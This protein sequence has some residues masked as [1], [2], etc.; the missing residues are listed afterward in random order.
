MENNSKNVEQEKARPLGKNTIPLVSETRDRIP[1]KGALKGYYTSDMALYDLDAVQTFLFSYETE[2][3]HSTE[4]REDSFESFMDDEY[5]APLLEM[6]YFIIYFNAIDLGNRKYHQKMMIEYNFAVKHNIPCLFV[7]PSL[8]ENKNETLAHAETIFGPRQFF[9]LYFSKGKLLDRAALTTKNKIAINLSRLAKDELHKELDKIFEKKAF[10]SYRKKDRQFIE[11]LLKAFHSQGGTHGLRIWYD[12]FLTG[13][14]EYSSDIEREL[15]SADFFIL[16]VTPSLLEKDNFVMRVEYPL[17]KKLGKII[18]PILVANTDLNEL[19]K[20]YPDLP[21]IIDFEQ[22]INFYDLQGKDIL[23]YHPD[24][25]AEAAKYYLTLGRCY[26]DGMEMEI[27]Y[28]LAEQMFKNASTYS[29]EGYHELARLYADEIFKKENLDL[30]IKYQEQYLHN[31]LP[32]LDLR[33][34]EDR[35]LYLSGCLEYQDY[36]LF[37]NQHTGFFDFNRVEVLRLDEYDEAS[38]LKF[39]RIVNIRRYRSNP[40][41]VKNLEAIEEQLFRLINKHI[42]LRPYIGL[43]YFEMAK[44]YRKARNKEKELE[45]GTRGYEFNLEYLNKPGIELYANKLV[46]YMQNMEYENL[47]DDKDF[48]KLKADSGYGWVWRL[49]YER[50]SKDFRF[51]REKIA[52]LIYRDYSLYYGLAPF[53]KIG[54]D[55]REYPQKSMMYYSYLNR[56]Y[57]VNNTFS[58]NQVVSEYGK[59]VINDAYP[60]IRTLYLE[61]PISY[62][63]DY[64]NYT[65][66]VA[67]EWKERDK[68]TL[69]EFYRR[70][71]LLASLGRGTS[72]M[73]LRAYQELSECLLNQSKK[74]E[75][76]KIL[77]EALKYFDSLNENEKRIGGSRRNQIIE[78]LKTI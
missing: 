31:S 27:D 43:F 39:I 59:R 2:I 19:N 77:N 54:Y 58:N 30:A 42:E 16:L 8:G 45:Y 4:T 20:Y 57:Q 38:L 73:A 7:H 47:D 63:I 1:L 44:C 24:D 51:F 48:Q 71:L 75:A 9:P 18:L 78:L 50:D 12:E 22:G 61:E 23:R 53:I 34:E 70:E 55:D 52:A 6:D 10:L 40:D 3:F 74:E 11:P 25:K 21:K 68:F 66:N 69:E 56:N 5:L 29:P 17:A 14:E 37:S 28:D 49:H 67:N 15:K 62:F 41:L 72:L 76:K 36:L 46:W 65:L 35:Y 64:V 13:G 33:N 26:R 32:L 60:Y